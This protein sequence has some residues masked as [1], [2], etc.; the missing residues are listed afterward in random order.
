MY[1]EYFL[2]VCE[3]FMAPKASFDKWKF[4]ILMKSNLLTFCIK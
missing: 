1:F 2:Q 4:L 3:A